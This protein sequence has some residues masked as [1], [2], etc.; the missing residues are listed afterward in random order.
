M[1]YMKKKN[2][3]KIT[4]KNLEKYTFKYLEKYAATEFQLRNILKRK[5]IKTSFFFQINPT[6]YIHFIDDIL[7]KFKKIGLIDDKKFSENR[8]LN[9]VKRG[10]SKRKILMNLKQKG[11]ADEIAELGIDNLKKFFFNFELASALIYAKKKKII[12][13]NKKNK[14]YQEE[15]KKLM[16]IS[17]AGFSYDI[18]KKLLN[19]NNKKEF[20]KLEKYANDGVD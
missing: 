15:E 3:K 14:S 6:D 4:Y 9:L 2:L 7:K 11:I 1:L 16:Q 13:F 10:F 18:G 5:I 17:R 19:L 8:A 12:S 20:I